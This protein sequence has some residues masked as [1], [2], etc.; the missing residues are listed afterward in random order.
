MTRVY[1]FRFRDPVK[2]CPHCQAL[3]IVSSYFEHEHFCK[4]NVSPKGDVGHSPGGGYPVAVRPSVQMTES[5]RYPCEDSPV[6]G[7]ASLVI[8]DCGEGM[9]EGDGL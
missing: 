8:S 9:I 1:D 7:E 3:V 4:N 6:H 2:R 5:A